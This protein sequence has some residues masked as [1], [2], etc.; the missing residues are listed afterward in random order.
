MAQHEDG[1]MYFVQG[2]VQW[3]GS[4]RAVAGQGSKSSGSSR[5]QGA[6]AVAGGSKSSG[7]SRG[8]GSSGSSRRQ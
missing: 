1:S 4:S 6:V 8:S 7:S 2:K 5:A 3:G